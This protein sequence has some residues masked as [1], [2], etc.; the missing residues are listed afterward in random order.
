M[1]ESTLR[2]VWIYPDLLSTYGDRGNM[3]ILAARAARRGIGVET[4]AQSHRRP[5][6]GD[7]N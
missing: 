6:L 3:L 7:E 4:L 2:I 1:T 5:L